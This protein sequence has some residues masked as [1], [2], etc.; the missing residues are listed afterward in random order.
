MSIYGQAVKRPITT[1]MIFI[2]LIVLGIYSLMRLPVDLYPEVEAPFMSVMTTYSG[3]NASDIETNVTR[4]IEDELNIVN[5]VKE[6]TSQSRDNI[7]VIFVEFEWGTDLDEAANDIRDALNFAEQQLPEDADKP[8]IFKFN[9]S[10]MPIM[11][12]AITA[13]ESYYGLEKILDE[14]VVNPLNRIEGIGSIGIM[15]APG[16]EIQV[17]VDPLRMEAYNLTIEQISSVIQAENLDMPAGNVEMGSM[18]YPLRIE[19]EFVESEVIKNLVL[20]NFNGQTIYLHDVATVKDTIKDMTLDEKINGQT[21]LRM[22]VQKQSGANTVGIAQEVRESLEELKK[23]LPADV[24]IE[25]IFDS[26]EFIEGSINNLTQTLLYAAIA[27]ILV[28][29]FFLGR[30]RATFIVILTIPISLIVAFIYLR[31]TG[32]SINIISLSSLSIAIGMVVDDAIVVLENITKHI[33]RGS[34]PREAAIYAT[35][36][37]WL[38]VIVTTLTVVAVFFPLTFVSGLT[39]TLFKQLGYIVTITVV[40]STVAAISLT[41]MLASK[42]LKLKPKKDRKPRKLSYDNTV[43]RLLNRIDGFYEKSIRTALR[44]KWPVLILAILVF[45]GSLSLVSQIGTEFMPESDE[46]QITAEIELQSGLRVDE[47]IRIARQID[48]IINEKMPESQLV[49]TSAGADDQGGWTALFSSSGSN[50]INYTISLVKPDQRDRGVKEIAGMFRE[51]MDKIPEIVT[52]NV[53]TSSGMGFGGNT[54]Q[55]DVEIFGYDIE[56]TNRIAREVAERLKTVPG[57]TDINISREESKPELQIMLDQERMAQHGLN[58]AAVSMMVRNR[59]QGLTTTRF[60]EFG[61]EYDVVVRFEEDYRNSITNVENIA[62]MNSQGETVRLKDIG[63]VKEVFTPPNIQRKRKERIVTV[64]V[65]PYKTSLG[66]LA[67]VIQSELGE[68]NTPP[69]VMIQVSGA[70]EDQQETFMDLAMLMVVS[71]LL[72][73]IVMASQFESLKMP[74]IIMFSIPFSFSGVLLALYFTNTTLSAISALGA[75]ML[76]GIVVKNAIVLV[77]YINLQRDRGLALN[78][79]IAVSGKSRLRP[80][81]MTS[82]TT[83]LGMLPLAMST[84]EGS[85]I[86]SPMGIAVIGGLIFSTI[87]TL[88]LVPVIYSMTSRR[89]ER[90]KLK[91]VHSRYVFMDKVLEEAK[92]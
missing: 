15:G 21:G 36:E 14:R 18:D 91:N 44:F 23:T 46:S 35:N 17:N 13:E 53:S 5:N 90:N 37:V 30:W 77:D 88:I 83:I 8:S 52:Y 87:V 41:P 32:N 75:I 72:V 65:K 48:D 79:A 71:L 58:T 40:T 60:R 29:L 16:R 57:A 11:F 20:G 64:S 84:G 45:V 54:N 80:V 47:T 55:V 66:E 61:D 42:L 25:P 3:A 89:G 19:G 27:V 28:V 70:F 1:I 7:S 62:I 78:E 59:V 81:L 51:E 22:I 2:G 34:T 10:M 43:L 74:F 73:Y 39:G 56:T 31:I 63:V 50:I 24:K 68:I 9:S 82:L 92:N 33:E 38:A 6:I 4:I 49:S 67:A 85:E 76:I 26:S 86:W 69:E 12:Y